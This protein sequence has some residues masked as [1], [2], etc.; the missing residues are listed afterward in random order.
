MRKMKFLSS[1]LAVVFTVQNGIFLHAAETNFW[2]ER[3]AALPIAQPA[4]SVLLTK[5]QIAL[6]NSPTFSRVIPSWLEQSFTPFATI[7]DEQFSNDKKA[8]TVLL[9]QDAHLH[10]EAQSNSAA[11]LSA[12]GAEMQKHG[13]SAILALEAAPSGAIDL[14]VY[15]SYP[16][17]DALTRVA[18]ALLEKNVINGAEC[19]VISASHPMRTFGAETWGEYEKNVAAFR[20]AN[21]LKKKAASTLKKTDQELIAKK[22]KIY[23]EGLARYDVKRSAHEEGTLGLSEWAL[24]LDSIAPATTPNT[25]N[26]INAALLEKSLDYT[27]VERQREQLLERLVSVLNQDE[28]A[29]L[30][31]ASTQ[32]RSGRITAANFYGF[33]KSLAERKGV[34]L[35][36]YPDMNLYVQYVAKSEGIN[37]SQL[38]TDMLAWEKVVEEKLSVSPEQRALL[39]ASRSQRLLKKLSTFELT[40]AEW[41]ELSSLAMNDKT[42]ASF[43][44]FYRIASQRNESMA[45]HVSRALEKANEQYGVVVVGGFHAEGLKD[46]LVERG[47]DVV[48]ISPRITHISNGP[49]SLDFLASNQTPLDQLFVGERLFLDVPRAIVSPAL[50]P[51]II[52]AS[53]VIATGQE[54]KVARPSEGN[55]TPDLTVDGKGIKFKGAARGIPY[56]IGQSVIAR[57]VNTTSGSS[58]IDFLVGLIDILNESQDVRSSSVVQSALRNQPGKILSVIHPQNI[59]SAFDNY[60]KKRIRQLSDEQSA[61]FFSV[62]TRFEKDFVRVGDQIAKE[63][64]RDF[65][66]LQMKAM[67]KSIAPL[68]E[69]L[70]T[71]EPRHQKFFKGYSPLE[72]D[73]SEDR[74]VRKNTFGKADAYA[75]ELSDLALSFGVENIKLRFYKY[76]NTTKY[77]P[78]GSEGQNHLGQV[79]Q[80]GNEWEVW[81]GEQFYKEA[82]GRST[83]A[84]DRR[85]RRADFFMEELLEGPLRKQDKDPEKDRAIQRAIHAAWHAVLERQYIGFSNSSPLARAKVVIEENSDLFLPATLA[86]VKKVKI[87]LPSV[88]PSR[89]QLMDETDDRAVVY[90]PEKKVDGKRVAPQLLVVDKQTLVV[91]ASLDVFGTPRI[92]RKVNVKNKKDMLVI[93]FGA[94]VHVFEFRSARDIKTRVLFGPRSNIEHLAISP[95][96]SKISVAESTEMG[97]APL[98]WDLTD[99]RNQHF[100]GEDNPN[101]DINDYATVVDRGD[102]IISDRDELDALVQAAVLPN[103]SSSAKTKSNRSK[104]FVNVATLAVLSPLSIALLMVIPM[105]SGSGA[106]DLSRLSDMLAFFPIWILDPFYAYMGVISGAVAAGAYWYRS[107]SPSAATF[108]SDRTE[109]QPM[110]I[111]ELFSADGYFLGVR[112]QFNDDGLREWRVYMLEEGKVVWENTVKHEVISGVANPAHD[113]ILFLLFP[114]Y[115]LFLLF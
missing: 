37:G 52:G 91:T 115:S 90:L 92:V 42:F 101:R 5:N 49:S 72:L 2:K 4:P 3:W 104:G 110:Q 71:I 16:H 44:D 93:T 29:T 47:F 78:D 6:Q 109:I 114:F 23:D 22:K 17:R 84:D 30:V 83:D 54:N 64:D 113:R 45:S 79:V 12:M 80:V 11:A 73:N 107:K 38:I 96:G 100:S 86:K 27:R 67:L 36:R 39:Q 59:F 50:G 31:N 51:V 75:A 76:D 61:L 97:T 10:A 65:H 62:L 94:T 57:F 95:D 34:S 32:L 9:F 89:Q 21:G 99:E 74:D 53:Q 8:K 48:T 63:I 105:I 24:Y 88:L 19:A 87:E 77:L 102:V 33:F 46:A 14:S 43:N 18:R 1:T 40:R 70:E 81:M 25:K 98:L 106:P 60:F 35:S 28:S 7:A 68:V 108:R 112:D 55:E 13:Q 85:A 58:V 103:S 82:L 66:T 111:R 15:S 56:S 26:L 41:S 20:E 69:L